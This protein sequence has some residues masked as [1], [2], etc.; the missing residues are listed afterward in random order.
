MSKSPVLFRYKAFE[1]HSSTQQ[2]SIPL[3]SPSTV[4]TFLRRT[5]SP[6]TT[7]FS[8]IFL[9]NQFS[10]HFLRLQKKP[11]LTPLRFPP[12]KKVYPIAFYCLLHGTFSHSQASTHYGHINLKFVI[13]HSAVT[14]LPSHDHFRLTEVWS[15]SPTGSAFSIDS[16]IS[17]NTQIGTTRVTTAHASS[18][19]PKDNV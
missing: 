14:T 8:Y 16:F 10:R 17:V 15:S 9:S 2:D 12:K 3:C 5:R 6:P 13:Y 7:L 1:S 11:P 4:A 19:V 18:G